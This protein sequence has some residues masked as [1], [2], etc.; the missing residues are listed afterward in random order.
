V[1][2]SDFYWIA[3]P[4]G[5][6]QTGGEIVASYGGNKISI[7]KNYSDTLYIHLNDA[8]MNLDRPIKLVYEGRRLFE[9]KVKRSADVLYKTV[10]ER[11]DA[12]LV[13][14]VELMIVKGK[15]AAI[16]DVFVKQ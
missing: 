12:G 6:E 13:F 5:S 3:V 16:N 9:G 10:N 1:H 2:H 4:E 11:K 14:P 8:M 15:L 7:E